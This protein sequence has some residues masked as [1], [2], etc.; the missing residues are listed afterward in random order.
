MRIDLHRINY[1]DDFTSGYLKIDERFECYSLED[2]QRDIKVDGETCI[3]SGRYEIKKRQVD[4]PLTLRYRK[5]FNWFDYHLEL[6]D[7]PGFDYVY[8]HIGNNDNHT[9]GCVLVGESINSDGFLGS[10]TSAFKKFY[11]KVSHCL[12]IGEKVEIFIH[13]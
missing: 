4:S 3:P 8:A 12:S 6:Q 10:S 1:Q 2:E 9:D 5:K 11:Q 13:S 7:V